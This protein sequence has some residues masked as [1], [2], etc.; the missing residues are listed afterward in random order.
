MQSS[1]S[2]A[3]LNLRVVSLRLLPLFLNLRCINIVLDNGNG[4]WIA[5]AQSI[6]NLSNIASEIFLFFS[7]S[8]SP[9]GAYTVCAVKSS[10][11]DTLPIQRIEMSMTSDER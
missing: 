3:M 4:G 8:K 2:L 9:R 6:L 7:E 1:S 10:A 11:S 5:A